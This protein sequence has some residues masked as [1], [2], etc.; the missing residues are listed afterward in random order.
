MK[1]SY[2]HDDRIWLRSEKVRQLLGE[3][4]PALVRW[5]IVIIIAIFLGL[6]A[7]ILTVPSIIGV[8]EWPDILRV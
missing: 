7:A 5:G 4:P 2:I 3:I 6:V 8:E 1:D